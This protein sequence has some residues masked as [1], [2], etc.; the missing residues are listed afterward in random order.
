MVG[1]GAVGFSTEDKYQIRRVSL[2][3]WVSFRLLELRGGG[4]FSVYLL[5]D[6]FIPPASDERELALLFFLFLLFC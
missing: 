1:N 4:G 3:S 6:P 2:L 5:V